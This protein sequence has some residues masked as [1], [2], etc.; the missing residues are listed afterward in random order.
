MIIGDALSHHTATSP[1]WRARPFCVLLSRSSVTTWASPTVH[2]H[3][4]C[5]KIHS[6]I[7]QRP[8]QLGRRGLFVFFSLDQAS[9]PGP[10]QLYTSILRVVKSTQSSHSDQSNL[11]GA[12]FL[13]SSLSIKRHHLGQPSCTHPSYVL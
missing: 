10:A 12:A 8:V 2:I 9:P 1:T 13:C 4:T 11:E 6:V 7:T 5:C 3:L